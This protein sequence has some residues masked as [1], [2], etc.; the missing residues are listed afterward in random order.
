MAIVAQHLWSMEAQVDLGG[1]LQLNQV[2]TDDD[3]DDQ[4]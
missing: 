1:C 3:K 4:P 2:D